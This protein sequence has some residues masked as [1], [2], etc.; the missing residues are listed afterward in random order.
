MNVYEWYIFTEALIGAYILIAVFLNKKGLLERYHL[1]LYGPFIMWKTEKGKALLER[2]AKKERFWKAYG[3]ISIVITVAA[4]ILMMVLLLWSAV[5]VLSIPADRSPEPKHIV[6]LPGINP[7]IPLWYG[8]MALAVAIVIHEG[9]HGILSL[10]G[11]LKVK[12]LG[13]LFFIVPVG[14]FVEPDEEALKET[15]PRIRDR[16]AAVGP[17]TNILFALLCAAMFSHIFMAAIEPVE[18][19]LLITGIV[20][21]SPAERGGLKAG[22]ILLNISHI[23]NDIEVENVRIRTYGDFNDFMDER[24][25]QDQVNLYVWYDGEKRWFQNV[26]LDERYEFTKVKEDK[27]DAYIGIYLMGASTEELQEVLH[28]PIASADDFGELRSNMLNYAIVPPFSG[29]VPFH[30]PFTDVY[31]PSGAIADTSEP[32]FWLLANVM[33]W[34]FWLN[35]MVGISNALPAVPFDG[36]YLFHDGATAFFTKLG[37]SKERTERATG[38][39]LLFVSLLVFFLVIWQVIGPRLAAGFQ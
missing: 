29:L 27:D 15:K 19:G 7:V 16:M 5:Y 25:P 28:H 20:E 10:V 34:L 17:A 18:D 12:S 8:I 14:A 33:Y 6:G 22:M 30:E 31:E 35:L 37:F 9:A 4:M 24:N 38:R 11:K 23:V 2:M 1:Q 32:L 26:T 21:D 13:L 39:S 3:D 36:S